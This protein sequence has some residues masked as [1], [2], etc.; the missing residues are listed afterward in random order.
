[1]WP[2]TFEKLSLEWHAQNGDLFFRP[3]ESDTRILWHTLDIFGKKAPA[4]VLEEAIK[5]GQLRRALPLG[6]EETIFLRPEEGIVH[7]HNRDYGAAF[8]PR[9]P[10]RGDDLRALLW[11]SPEQLAA[12]TPAF[13]GDHSY[14]ENARR[15][16]RNH[17]ERSPDIAVAQGTRRDLELLLR[18]LSQLFP[19]EDEAVGHLYLCFAR[20]E[21]QM[22]HLEG[23]ERHFQAPSYC[24]HPRVI[25]RH[26][27]RGFSG[28]HRGF[29]GS[30]DFEEV[31]PSQHER[32]EALLVWRDFLRD[33][34]TPAEIES[35]LST[36]T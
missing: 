7:F 13:L 8:S 11:M 4:S 10:A 34:M 32:L 30:P 28:W 1:M 23:I 36:T 3:R 2:A 33:K 12:R 29:E 5:L 35:L 22:Q 27:V 9:F 25:Y 24:F 21:F 20:E 19:D 17:P 14:Y 18:A 16:L 6:A 31:A 15:W 26:R